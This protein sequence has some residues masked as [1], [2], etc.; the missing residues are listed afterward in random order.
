MAWIPN[1]MIAVP[2]WGN[3]DLDVK[4]DDSAA[5]AFAIVHNV[6]V[7]EWVKDLEAEVCDKVFQE[8]IPFCV[9]NLNSDAFG[10]SISYV[11]A[12]HKA[13]MATS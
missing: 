10:P 3:V 12:F 2:M 6:L 9:K 13:V 8:M 4:D 1:G 11:S 5:V 7:K